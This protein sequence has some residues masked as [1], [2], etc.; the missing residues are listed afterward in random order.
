MIFT[1]TD[2]EGEQVLDYFHTMMRSASEVDR[3]LNEKDAMLLIVATL[4][5]TV[6][7]Q[8]AQIADLHERLSSRRS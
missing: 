6:V 5:K 4:C 3:P 1:D 2:L 7:Q 8:Q